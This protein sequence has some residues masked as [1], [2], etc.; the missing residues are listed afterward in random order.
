MINNYGQV[1][2]LAKANRVVTKY[3]RKYAQQVIAG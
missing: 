2:Y 3:F 1:Y